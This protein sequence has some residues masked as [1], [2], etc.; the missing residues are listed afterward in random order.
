M[1][2]RVFITACFVLLPSWAFAWGPL[3]HMYL[4]G[5]ALLL[6]VATIP[7]AVRELIR[8]YRQDFLY[9]NIMADSILAKK[10]LPHEH[11]PHNWQVALDLYNSASTD[12]DRAFSLGY[13]C[14][15]AADTVAHGPYTSDYGHLEH[16][17][18]EFRA[19]S[20]IC[21]SHWFK[22]LS[23]NRDVR[24]RNNR[25]IATRLQTAF[26]SHRVNRKLFKG[27]VAFSGIG[28]LG[29]K[30][31]NFAGLKGSP[32]AGLDIEELLEALHEDSLKRMT[33]VLSDPTGS[34]VL[35]MNAI[36]DTPGPSAYLKARVG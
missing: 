31:K 28:S 26:F 34:D 36:A 13:L 22:A 6:S 17:I 11:H 2:L 20:Y 7:I 18:V 27:F 32:H 3:T 14:H 30:M 8:R 4:G 24:K 33:S 5:E 10:Y 16:S 19:D 9:G 21:Q 1:V 29:R 35:K 25:F 15:L 12:S 23:I